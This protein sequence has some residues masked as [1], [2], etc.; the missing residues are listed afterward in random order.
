MTGNGT[1]V[2]VTDC[3]QNQ[4]QWPAFPIKQNILSSK[5]AGFRISI[6]FADKVL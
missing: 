4:S 6:V 5:A 3:R 2:T 1:F